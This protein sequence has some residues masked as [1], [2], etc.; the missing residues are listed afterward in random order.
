MKFVV[1]C[2][3][4]YEL[5]LKKIIWD[6]VYIAWFSYLGLFLCLSA[7]YYSILSYLTYLATGVLDL[8]LNFPGYHR[9]KFTDFLRNIL[10]MLVSIAWVIILLILYVHS[11]NK[12]VNIPIK[13]LN[14]WL[15]QSKGGSP[16]YYLAVAVYLLPNALT[17]LLFLFPM[18]RRWIENSDWLVTRML[19]WWSQVSKTLSSY[20]CHPFNSFLV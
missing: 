2:I 16:I 4:F 19:L 18:F 10:K 11:S 17:V 20:N 9:W 7:L 13:G 3:L 14:D 15:N 1:R 8:V 6:H 5:E 12:R